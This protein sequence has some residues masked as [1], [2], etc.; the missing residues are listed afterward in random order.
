MQV[1]QIAAW[2]HRE[3]PLEIA[4]ARREAKRLARRIRICDEELA[5]NDAELLAL[6]KNSTAASLLNE[7]GIGPV[8]AAIL[9][10]AWSHPGRVRNEAAFASL[11]GVAPI[12]ASSGNTTRHRL[13][14][15]GDRLL[16]RALYAITVNRMI[17]DPMTRQYAERKRAEGR[18]TK[19][20]RR[21]LKRYICRHLYRALEASA[22]PPQTT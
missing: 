6:V 3:E 1:A 10:T 2:R 22:A 18:T 19:E 4:A 14:R 7:R 12:P 9:L 13:N 15:G 20:I 21:S 16:N 8:N 11:A 5:E 17:H